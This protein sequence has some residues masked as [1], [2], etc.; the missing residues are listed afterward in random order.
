MAKIILLAVIVFIVYSLAKKRPPKTSTPRAREDMV[1]CAHCGL[2]QPRSESIASGG[3]YFCCEEH[4][5]QH[6]K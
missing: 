5:N 2:H 1:R 3:L 6:A 4:R